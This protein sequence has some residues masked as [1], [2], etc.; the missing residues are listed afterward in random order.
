[1]KQCIIVGAGPEGLPGGIPNRQD[2]LIIAADGGYR[3]LLERGIEPDLLVGDFDSLSAP[4][5]GLEVLP[6]PVE[7]DDTDM[8]A[9]IRHGLSCG[10][11][12]FD[13]YGGVG[14]RLDHTLANLQCLGY[15]AR[16]GAHGFLHGGDCV[17]TCI[18]DS[19]MG[20]GPGN[21]GT[22]SVFCLAGTAQGVT[23]TGLKYPLDD[24]TMTCLFP[25]GVSNA[26]TQS[27]SRISV[28]A[29]MLWVCYPSQATGLFF[30]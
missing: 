29:G 23:L 2:A 11:R 25:I 13:L 28:S 30:A 20:F 7:K 19:A 15:L 10:C 5:P 17:F 3:H 6:L 27:A 22:V 8:L 26:F 21:R 12:R 9:A 24:Y 4:P 1:M 18:Q 14:G 16:Q